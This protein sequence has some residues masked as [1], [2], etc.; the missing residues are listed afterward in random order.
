MTGYV[1]SECTLENA[2][3]PAK[4]FDDKWKT[5]TKF[6]EFSDPV[7]LKSKINDIKEWIENFDKKL[8]MIYDADSLGGIK[9]KQ[10]KRCRDLNYY[11]NYVLHYIP[12]ITKDTENVA[13]IKHDFQTYLNAIFAKWE[14]FSTPTKFDCKRKVK[15]YT[16]KMDLI[17][18]L[19]DYCENRNAFKNKLMQY[20]KITCCKY[21]KHVNE[22]K[23]LF[24]KYILS[25][26]VDKDDES[27][28]IEENCSLKKFGKTFPNVTCNDDDMSEI[29]SDDL[30]DPYGTGYLFSSQQHM[31]P[32]IHMENSLSSSP[33]K[34][35]LTSVST[36]LGACLSGL[37]LYRH[38]FVG[39]M[40]RNLQNK[41]HIS[42]EDTYDD[43]NGMFSEG[44][45]HYLSTPA[46]NDKF[47]ISYDS[48]NN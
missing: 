15:E 11:V 33:T 44:A 20:N 23:R 35:A 29:E 45:S 12:E 39:S 1:V 48:I 14:K 10:D 30:L 19:D 17:K 40:L 16:S 5:A 24:H 2:D 31:S 34:I 38:S 46:D 47:Y 43:I 42:N 28:N 26:Q 7:N 6:L 4:D 27:F 25:N 32:G 37:Y 18:S 3:L 9:D 36:L 22:M 21:A 8:F 41:N 13:Q